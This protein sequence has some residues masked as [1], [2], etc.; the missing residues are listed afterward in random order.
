MFIALEGGDGVGKST[1]IA[2]LREWLEAKGER[3]TFFREPGSTALGEKVRELLLFHREIGIC[4]MSELLLFMTARAQVVS[5]VIRPALE[6]GEVVLADR[7]LLSSIVYQGYGGELD[8]EEIRRLGRIAAGGI[9]PDRNL[10][11]DLPL[12]AAKTR[13]KGVPDR[14]ESE[15][16]AF[17]ERVRNGFLKEAELFPEQNVLISA[18]QPIEAVQTEIREAVKSLWG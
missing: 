18:D 1:Q 2:L 16:D 8:V 12:E 5:E 17:H 11:L 7:F 15:A 3:V 14:I 4:R 10:I 6:R 13:R 9:L